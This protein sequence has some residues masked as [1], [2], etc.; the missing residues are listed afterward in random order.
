[1]ENSSQN[2]PNP[3]PNMPN[4]AP[5]LP[6]SAPNLPNP[7]QNQS[8]H[9]DPNSVITE[10]D[11]TKSENQLNKLLDQLKDYEPIIPDEI[12]RYFVNKGGTD[13]KDP[14]VLRLFSV[15]TQKILTDIIVDAYSQNQLRNENRNGQNIEPAVLTTEDLNKALNE[16]GLS[17]DKPQF[18]N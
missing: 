9:P 4:S 18:Y 5:N 17:C 1:M 14:R 16:Y 12:T 13:T 15:V 11:L 10:Q 2:L 6:N 8:P 7:S 3:G